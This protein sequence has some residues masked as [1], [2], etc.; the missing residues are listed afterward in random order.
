MNVIKSIAV[1]L[2]F[3]LGFAI[4]SPLIS[5][6]VLSLL[7][8]ARGRRFLGLRSRIVCKVA[9]VVGGAPGDLCCR[10]YLGIS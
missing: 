10:R 6:A 5:V 4:V 8:A 1:G 7:S 3:V 2:L 9:L